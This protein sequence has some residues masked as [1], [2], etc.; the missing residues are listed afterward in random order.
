MTTQWAVI[1]VQKVRRY[2]WNVYR[3]ASALLSVKIQCSEILT[4]FAFW[5]Y[6]QLTNG[7]WLAKAFIKM[8]NS[9]LGSMLCSL[10]WM[11]LRC[12]RLN[13]KISTNLKNIMP[14]H[15]SKYYCMSLCIFMVNIMLFHGIQFCYVLFW[16]MLCFFRVKVKRIRY[17]Y[18]QTQQGLIG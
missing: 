17:P 15:S 1:N 5:V 7:L 8:L 13:C 9:F 18:I 3:W 10:R 16:F 14:Y 11:L 4:L 6:Y 2:R 12:D